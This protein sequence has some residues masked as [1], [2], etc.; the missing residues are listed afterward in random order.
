MSQENVEIVRSYFEAY[1]RE[2][3]EGWKALLASDVEF[4]PLGLMGGSTSGVDNVARSISEFAGA[5]DSYSVSPEAFYEGGDQVVVAFHRSAQSARSPAS[6]D[7]Q[8]AQWLTLR[9]GRI[10]RM[11]SFRRVHEALEAAGLSE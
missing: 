2:D 8:F 7:D 10:V 11:Q 1:E 4:L 3:H 6:I 5:F 9:D